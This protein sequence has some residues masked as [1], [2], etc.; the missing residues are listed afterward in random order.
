MACH[1]ARRHRGSARRSGAT[2]G[3]SE[4]PGVLHQELGEAAHVP[5]RRPQVVGHGVEQRLQLG[6]RGR[7]ARRRARRAGARARRSVAPAPR[8]AGRAGS[9][10]R[11]ASRSPA[12]CRDAP[13]R[14]RRRA[15]AA[16][17]TSPIGLAVD[18]E[19][20]REHAAEP[21][22]L[23]LAEDRR[24]RIQRRDVL[25]VPDR[26]A[27]EDVGRG[28]MLE[29]QRRGREREAPGEPGEQSGLP[30][31]E[32]EQDD[33]AALAGHHPAEP[34]QRRA[35]DLGR[36]ARGEDRLIHVVQHREPLGRSAEPLLGALALGDVGE[37]ADACR[38]GAPSRP[39][40]GLADTSPHS[41]LPSFR[42]NRRSEARR[43]P[44]AG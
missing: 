39:V 11:A 19:R 25:A 14:T 35:A 7:A 42:R 40:I 44:S 6:R 21:V 33:A 20:H 10:W 27:P 32:V 13:R 23:E 15:V 38:R 30:A 36:R 37:H 5:Q 16:R 43:R 18:Q 41:S 28:Q 22:L 8:G 3:S 31:L 4:W 1:P 17:F 34:A 12:R 2:A 26:A 9:R 29:R 24:R